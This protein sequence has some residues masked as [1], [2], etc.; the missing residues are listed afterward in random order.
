VRG[1]F[2]TPDEHIQHT[3]VM[4][5][6]QLAAG[7]IGAGATSLGKANHAEPG[8]YH[9]AFFG[10]SIGIE[11]LCKLIFIADFAIQ[12]GGTFPDQKLLR[13]LGHKID[14]LLDVCEE[15]GTRVD[16]SRTYAERPDSPIHVAIV[17][18]LTEFATSARYHNI[19]FLR[20]PRSAGRDPIAAWWVDVG[21]PICQEHYR[22]RNRQRDEALAE[23]LGAV[24]N[25][26][27]FV[28]MTAETGDPID[29]A[30]AM[31][32]R[33]GATRVVQRYGRM[34]TLQIVRW[35]VSIA[36]ELSHTAGYEKRIAGLFCFHE[37]LTGFLVEDSYM[38]ERKTWGPYL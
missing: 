37:A 11:R 6:A 17:R 7:Q 18:L 25:R 29:D 4:R 30:V 38:R 16:Q 33:Q 28:M 35:L 21:L 14:E 19:T 10:L 1:W 15:I 5:E 22:E 26:T 31:M 20:T 36:W 8:Y 34:Y 23:S 13:D 27:A 3:A 32:K 9:Q 24:V 12:H 2:V